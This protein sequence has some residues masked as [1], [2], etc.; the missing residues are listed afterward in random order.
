M[1]QAPRPPW[2]WSPRP[3]CGWCGF[4]GGVNFYLKFIDFLLIFI[5]WPPP[6]PCGVGWPWGLFGYPS[7]L[8][9][10]SFDFHPIVIDVV[11]CPHVQ[12]QTCIM[13]GSC[14]HWTTLNYVTMVDAY[15]MLCCVKR[16]NCY[17]FRFS[18]LFLWFFNDFRYSHYI[19]SDL[20]RCHGSHYALL[21][22][23]V[24]N[25]MHNAVECNGII[26]SAMYGSCLHWTT[27][28][29]PNGTCY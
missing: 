28:Y 24:L 12:V 23:V 11:I 19:E 4:G 9:W 25:I 22:F 13:H 21:V 5:G 16:F 10:F 15:T 18:L 17:V 6:L 20:V 8:H 1:F 3:P 7:E 2:S 26:C 27:W 29:H 14:L